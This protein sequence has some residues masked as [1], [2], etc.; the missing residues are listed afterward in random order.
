ML[1]D[2]SVISIMTWYAAFQPPNLFLSLVY[3]PLSDVGPDLVL[4][5]DGHLVHLL[6]LGQL[7]DVARVAGEAPPAADLTSASNRLRALVIHLE[8]AVR[9]QRP[10]AL[11]GPATEQEAL[12][13]GEAVLIRGLLR[14]T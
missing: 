9:G 5:E 10:V 8:A 6:A 7:V 2:Q 11:L 14:A 1:Y 3:L 4:A 12:L 13:A